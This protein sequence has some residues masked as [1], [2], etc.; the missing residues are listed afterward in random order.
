MDPHTLFVFAGMLG[1]AL[2]AMVACLCLCR[3]LAIKRETLHQVPACLP[4]SGNQVSA[5]SWRIEIPE[6]VIGWGVKTNAESFCVPTLR[7]S[8]SLGED[9]QGS[10]QHGA[11]RF[12]K[13]SPGR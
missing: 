7:R 2:Y 5:P 3:A 9:S 12:K 4:A 13:S 6:F 10:H 11:G 1:K 8:T